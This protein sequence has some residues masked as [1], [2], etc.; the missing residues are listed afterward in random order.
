MISASSGLPAAITRDDAVYRFAPIHEADDFIRLGWMSTPALAGIHHGH[1]SV[2]M[3]WVCG[4]G[5]P[6]RV[7]RRG[8]S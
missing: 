1:W 3:M 6:M 4:C 2:L 5:R 8:P 7:P